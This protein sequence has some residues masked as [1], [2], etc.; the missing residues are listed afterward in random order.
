MQGEIK[1]V[2]PVAMEDGSIVL[3]LTLHIK[4]AW[5]SNV[6]KTAAV[7]LEVDNECKVRLRQYAVKLPT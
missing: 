6:V 7:T 4:V 1:Q 5:H 3:V 2:S